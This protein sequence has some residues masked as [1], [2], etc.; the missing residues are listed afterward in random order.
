MLFV[1]DIAGLVAGAAEGAGLGNAFLSH[2]SAVDGL[3]HVSIEGARVNVS[4]NRPCSRCDARASQCICG[5][6]G[7]VFIDLVTRGHLFELWLAPPR[8]GLP[9]VQ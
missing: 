8:S 1:T 2:I 9:R 3:F 6:F 4:L 7:P 5:C